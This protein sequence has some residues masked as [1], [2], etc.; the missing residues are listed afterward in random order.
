MVIEKGKAILG[1]LTTFLAGMACGF[2]ASKIVSWLILLV[3]LAVVG[4]VGFGVYKYYTRQS[5]KK[6]M[7]N[8]QS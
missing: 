1:T 7:Q 2:F 8:V 5:K 3:A 6:E 4:L